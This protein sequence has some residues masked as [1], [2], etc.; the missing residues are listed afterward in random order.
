MR[1]MK[2]WDIAFNQVESVKVEAERNC[3]TNFNFSFDS[4][5]FLKQ[6]QLSELINKAMNEYCGGTFSAINDLCVDADYNKIK[7]NVKSVSCSYDNA[8]DTPSTTLEAGHLR[9]AFNWDTSNHSE[10][11]KNYLKK[12]L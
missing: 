9:F 3:A 11:V 12:N 10:S 6:T 5:S 1:E 8:I 7:T 4:D 2:L